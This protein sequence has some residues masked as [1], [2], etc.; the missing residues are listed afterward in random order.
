MKSCPHCDKTFNW[1]QRAIGEDKAHLKEC[2]EKHRENADISQVMSTCR[3]CPA[4]CY[5][6]VDFEKQDHI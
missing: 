5:D 1:W 2:A 4:G 6:R 3:G